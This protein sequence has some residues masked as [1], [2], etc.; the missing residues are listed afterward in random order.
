VGAPAQAPQGELASDNP[1]A[2][3]TVCREQRKKAAR[4][5]KRPGGWRMRIE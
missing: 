1:H 2:A 3:A 5:H 4:L